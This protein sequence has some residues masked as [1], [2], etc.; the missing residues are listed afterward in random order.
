[1][2]KAQAVEMGALH[3][4]KFKTPNKANVCRRFLTLFFDGKG[5]R[6]VLRPSDK[7]AASEASG[8]F[9][10][11]PASGHP[12]DKLRAG[13]LQRGARVKASADQSSAYA[14]VPAET[15]RC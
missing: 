7:G 6:I 8:G 3:N 4:Q 15:G 9:L 5:Q 10:T 1:M 12:F 2:K 13:S 14:S 11:P